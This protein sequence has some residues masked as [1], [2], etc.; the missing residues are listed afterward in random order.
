MGRIIKT[1]SDDK[2]DVRSVTLR[3]VTNQVFDRPI[4]KLV[5]L[6][7]AEDEETIKMKRKITNE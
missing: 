3:T 1:Q 2:G 5:L 6:V 7:E 4:H